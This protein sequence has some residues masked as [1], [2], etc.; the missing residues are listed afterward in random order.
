MKRVDSIF[1]INIGIQTFDYFWT[2][3]LISQKI[4]IIL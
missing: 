1:L 4:F 2:V 3:N